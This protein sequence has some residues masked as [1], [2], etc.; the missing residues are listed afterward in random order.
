MDH[1]AQHVAAHLTPVWVRKLS[2]RGVAESQKHRTPRWR[3]VEGQGSLEK[4]R[5]RRMCNRWYE[6][7]IRKHGGPLAQGFGI[8]K[9][10]VEIGITLNK[11]WAWGG[12]KRFHLLFHVRQSMC[13][14]KA[15]IRNIQH[16]HPTP[17]RDQP[18]YDQAR[19]L[20]SRWQDEQKSS[21]FTSW[22]RSWW[23]RSVWKEQWFDMTWA[24]AQCGVVQ[25]QSQNVQSDVRR[26]LVG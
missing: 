7:M 8:P 21:L 16:G 9:P 12:S 5:P 23:Q 26:N 25:R 11:I 13:T 20:A 24:L 4:G 18:D 10:N 14:G 17:L 1:E 3:S 22:S 6:G 2:Y 15:V 19:K